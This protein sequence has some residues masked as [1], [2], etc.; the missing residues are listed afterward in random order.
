MAA[1]EYFLERRRY[2]GGTWKSV[3]YHRFSRIA[4]V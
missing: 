3:M 4:I 2:V 1:S